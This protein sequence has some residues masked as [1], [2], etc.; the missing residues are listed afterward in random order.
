[1][2]THAAIRITAL[3]IL[4]AG[5]AAR[6]A[7]AELTVVTRYVLVNGDTLVRPSYYSKNRVRVTA[8]NGWEYM[9]DS[10]SD[11]V[12]VINHKSMTYWTGPR[13]QADTLATRIMAKNSQDVDAQVA[14][15][16]PVEYANKLQ[17]FNDSIKVIAHGKRRTIAGY[18]CDQWVLVAGSYLT[19]ERWIARSLNV[20]DYGP[21]MQKVVLA[22]IPD[23]L[24]RQLMR[25]MIDMRTKQ[26]LVLAGNA[27]FRTLKRAGSY[28]FEATS[29]KSGP[30]PKSAWAVPEGYHQ[31]AL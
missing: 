22:S 20:I 25:M 29:V 27:T 2:R 9:F 4:F 5:A 10:K 15:M 30:I 21:E 24:G 1:V 8:P 23:P 13:S 16:D 3:A 17:A 6:P 26:G 7:A 18:P 31:I 12:T 19:N 28:S 11:S 14:Q